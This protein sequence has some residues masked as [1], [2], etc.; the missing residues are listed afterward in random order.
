[1]ESE[2]TTMADV[3]RTS[4]STSTKA[5]Q[6]PASKSYEIFSCTV[7]KPAYAY[8][9]L[10]VRSDDPGEHQSLDAL[11]A[12]S[13]CASAMQQFLGVTGAAVTIDVLKVDAAKG[14]FWVR[15]PS[16]DLGRFSAAVTSWPG[17]VQSGVT[18]GLSILAAGDW[19]GSLLGR[20]EQQ[21][22]WSS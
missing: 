20:S 12:R 22:L 3:S 18:T 15:L 19:L 1:M 17:A 10:R 11:Q 2:D 8:A 4:V 6:N 14:E 21:S 9:H 13:Y 16:P 7:K 5:S